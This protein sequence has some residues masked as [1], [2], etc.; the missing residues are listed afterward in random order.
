MTRDIKVIG[1]DDLSTL[2][3]KK[4]LI[5]EVIIHTGKTMQTLLSLV[6]QHNLKVVKVAS[7]LVNR[8]PRNVGCRR[9]F[10]GFEIPDK[11]VIGYALDYNEYFRD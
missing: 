9:D 6:Q 2:T 4:V 7:L 5:I 10:V 8:I 3:G 11:F 1:R